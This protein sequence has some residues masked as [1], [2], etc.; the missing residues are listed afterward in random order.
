[1]SPYRLLQEYLNNDPWKIFVCCIFCNLTK[2]KT[3]EP[4]FWETLRRWP[5][6]DCL[7]DA[8]DDELIEL[9]TPLGL[10]KRRAKAL[11]TMSN[12]YIT[13]SWKSDPKVLFGIGKYG[14]DAYRI[15]CTK[16]WQ[17]VRPTDGALVK[18]KN[19]LDAQNC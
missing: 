6:P 1:M 2:R 14:S 19:W 10:S 18:Y 11:K 17:S 3:A 8:N 7:K 5:S 4:F 13:K 9:I 16:E 15:F 12:D